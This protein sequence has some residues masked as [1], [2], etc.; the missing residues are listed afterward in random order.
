MQQHK[1]NKTKKQSVVTNNL[2]ATITTL[3]MVRMFIRDLITM[4]GRTIIFSFKRT[5][6]KSPLLRYNVLAKEDFAMKIKDVEHKVTLDD[7]EHR[8]LVSC[9]NAARNVYLE[10]GKEIADLDELLIKIIEAP[11]KKVRVRI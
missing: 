6:S 11:S 4:P 7:F 5:F 9:I 3:C 8:L 1:R 2:S 10:Q